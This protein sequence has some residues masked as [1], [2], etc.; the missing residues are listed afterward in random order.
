MTISIEGQGL[1]VV[2]TMSNWWCFFMFVLAL[3]VIFLIG[4]RNFNAG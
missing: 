1:N 4:G 2:A 3:F